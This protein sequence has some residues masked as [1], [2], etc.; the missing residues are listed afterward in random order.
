MRHTF[1][2]IRVSSKVTWR[3]R[4]NSGLSPSD[5]CRSVHLG[6]SCV[7]ALL[8]WGL[9]C[10]EP[11]VQPLL[12]QVLIASESVLTMTVWR[13]VMP[14]LPSW[15]YLI[16]MPSKWITQYCM[17]WI[18]NLI[19]LSFRAVAHLYDIVL[20]MDV[21]GLHYVGKVIAAA[22]ANGIR[23]HFIPGRSTW[24]LQP[25]DAWIFVI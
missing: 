6:V 9:I 15:M 1:N 17:V 23:L 22:R 20:S 5:R 7:W 14:L 12:P 10:D 8:M 2:T 24:L 19:G 18:M 3:Y 25:L 21:L 13:A 16:R 11:L 4:R